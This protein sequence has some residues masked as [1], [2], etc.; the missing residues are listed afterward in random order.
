MSPAFCGSVCHKPCKNMLNKLNKGNNAQRLKHKSPCFGT[1]RTAVTEKQSICA[2]AADQLVS[3]D[4]STAGSWEAN[5]KCSLLSISLKD[6]PASRLVWL[7]N[8]FYLL[9]KVSSHLAPPHFL[10]CV[11][12]RRAGACRAAVATY[13]N[14][15][16]SL[17]SCG[18]TVLLID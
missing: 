4:L 2:T 6:F 11:S 10:H 18:R 13:L 16:P 12:L 15:A 14:C 8:C 17:V 5:V 1:D 3:D 7:I 9:V